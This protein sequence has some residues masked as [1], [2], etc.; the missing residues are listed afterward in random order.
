MLPIVLIIALN[1]FDA[2]ETSAWSG[3][4]H[5]LICDIAWQHMTPAAKRF[6]TQLRSN[7]TGTFA[8]SCT[9]A[10]DVVRRRRETYAY[11][12]VNIPRGRSGIVIARDCKAPQ[13]CVT[14]AIKHYHTILAD[15]RQPSAVRTEALKFLSHFVGDVHQPLHAAYASDRGGNRV[16]VSFFG[17]DGTAQRPMQLHAV[18]DSR[19][20]NRGHVRWPKAVNNLVDDITSAEIKSWSNW[21]VIGWTNESFLIAEDFAY[22]ARSGSNIAEPYYN[23]ALQIAKQRV[24]QAG[25][26]LAFLVNEAARGRTNFNF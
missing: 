23:R 17:D 26:R 16:Y 5:R 1:A 3:D 9:W 8:E 4:A 25:I 19:I 11:H 20:L 15:P 21:D 13:R 2:R 18:W 12:F 22:S 24:Q 10:D 7:E 14:W 6:A